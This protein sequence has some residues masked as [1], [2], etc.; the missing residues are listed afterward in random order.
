MKEQF[1]YTFS[2]L[3][4]LI[5]TSQSLLH[6]AI[7]AWWTL[8]PAGGVGGHGLTDTHTGPTV[9][10]LL[11]AQRL[12]EIIARDYAEQNLWELRA[13]GGRRKPALKDSHVAAEVRCDQALGPAQVPLADGVLALL[14]LESACRV[15]VD[16][17]R[18]PV[19]GP[20][21]LRKPGGHPVPLVALH[22]HYMVD[23]KNFLGLYLEK[24]TVEK[25]VQDPISQSEAY[26]TTE[27][28]CFV[29]AHK[30]RSA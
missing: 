4:H 17:Y 19:H 18:V 12:Q 7:N 5:A 23:S 13:G 16:A 25:T 6:T 14:V 15:D 27:G 9:H 10:Q 20:A 21:G 29:V 8:S 24:E 30:A 1:L 22:R 3:S 28:I 11:W 2:T 26:C